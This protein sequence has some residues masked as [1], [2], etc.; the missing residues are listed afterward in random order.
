MPSFLPSYGIKALQM[1]TLS[2]TSTS[3]EVLLEVNVDSWLGYTRCSTD[4]DQGVVKRGQHVPSS[5]EGVHWKSWTGL[6]PTLSLHSW[7]LKGASAFRWG[8]WVKGLVLIAIALFK[9][10]RGIK[11]N[12]FKVQSHEPDWFGWSLALAK[13]PLWWT[14]NPQTWVVVVFVRGVIV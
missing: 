1:Q 6:C 9:K 10:S 7:E 8:D 11:K 12:P 3:T 4:R 2:N 14:L 5:N 13:T